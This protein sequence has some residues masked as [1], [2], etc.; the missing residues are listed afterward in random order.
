ML[1]QGKYERKNLKFGENSGLS[2]RLKKARQMT[3]YVNHD[4]LR[5]QFLHLRVVNTKCRYPIGVNLEQS[6]NDFG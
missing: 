5:F 2:K 6:L 4:R 1:F 3:V